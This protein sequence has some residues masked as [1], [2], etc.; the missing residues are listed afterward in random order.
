M[1]KLFISQPM[2]GLKDEEILKTREEIKTRA[3][4]VIGEEVKIINSFI[5]EYP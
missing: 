5:D 4:I 1:K 2:R 3:E